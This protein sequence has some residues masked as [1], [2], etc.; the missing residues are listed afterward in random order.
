MAH[1][2]HF[3]IE[4]QSSLF[5]QAA[6]L[7]VVLGDSTSWSIWRTVFSPSL[8]RHTLKAN[9]GQLKPRSG[10]P[11]PRQ[12][13]YPPAWRSGLAV[14]LAHARHPPSAQ[15]RMIQ[16]PP[17][18]FSP[19]PLRRKTSIWTHLGRM[20]HLLAPPA[21]LAWPSRHPKRKP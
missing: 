17:R 4:T 13:K 12:A 6:R 10:H 16:P 19:H 14:L 15:Q 20:L 9:H 8:F 21:S 2:S 1:V 3:L 7:L 5:N 11:R 18:C